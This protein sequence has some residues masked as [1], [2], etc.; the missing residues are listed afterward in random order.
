MSL[1]DLLIDFYLLRS[2]LKLIFVQYIYRDA[3][4]AD[5]KLQNLYRLTLGA[6]GLSILIVTFH[7]RF[8]ILIPAKLVA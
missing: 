6:Y 4:I 8:C 1:I 7:P 2:Y 5:E 3:T